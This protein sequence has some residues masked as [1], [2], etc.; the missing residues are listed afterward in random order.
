MYVIHLDWA[1]FIAQAQECSAVFVESYQEPIIVHGIRVGYK[2]FI[3]AAYGDAARIVHAARLLVEEV[4]T[5]TP[6]D[7]RNASADNSSLALEVVKTSIQQ[8]SLDVQHGLLLAPGLRDDLR[9]THTH[10]YLWSWAHPKDPAKR[11]LVPA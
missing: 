11:Q 5:L 6:D 4:S 3:Q 9:T 1:D 7:T 8:R 10:H 2:Y